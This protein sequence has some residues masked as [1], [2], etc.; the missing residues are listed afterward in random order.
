MEIFNMFILSLF[1]LYFNF[2][3]CNYLFRY[4]HTTSLI[5]T[6]ITI[7]NNIKKDIIK[8][9]NNILTLDF[10]LTILYNI[11]YIKYNNLFMEY[12]NDRLQF[13]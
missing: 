5:S 12:I 4:N 11:Y 8:H 7:I 6:F 10:I 1:A 9:K 13:N 3:L 2:K